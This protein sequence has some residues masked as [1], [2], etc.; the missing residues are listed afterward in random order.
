[1][2]SFAL[3]TTRQAKKGASRRSAGGPRL[4][5]GQTKEVKTT[6]VISVH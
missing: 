2:C 6:E 5:S 1:M 4:A 3:W